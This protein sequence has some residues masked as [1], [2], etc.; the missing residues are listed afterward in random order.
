MN[1][2]V[3]KLNGAE[4]A[5]A[6][7][8]KIEQVLWN[9]TTNIDSTHASRIVHGSIVETWASRQPSLARRVSNRPAVTVVCTVD[10]RML[11]LSKQ[12]SVVGSNAGNGSCVAL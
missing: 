5:P 7:M 3:E 4:D 1:G 10:T 12:G 9:V 2:P 8:I 11:C 6:C